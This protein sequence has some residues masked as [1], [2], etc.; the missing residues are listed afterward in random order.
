MSGEKNIQF[1]QEM[2]RK[3]QSGDIPGLLAG[4]TENCAWDH[5]GADL[6]FNGMFKGPEGVGK[7]FGQ[8]ADL[9]EPLKFEPREFISDGDKVVA[10]G[11]F[12]WKV[13]SNGNT[14]G[15]DFA[16]VFTITEGK[17]SAFKPYWDQASAVAAFAG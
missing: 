7:F 8:L 1:V 9:V 13:K 3:F 10:L 4:L 5:R 16:H 6:P 14:Y 2:Y 12:E 17:A 15:A 11:S